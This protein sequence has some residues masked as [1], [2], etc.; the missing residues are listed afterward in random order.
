MEN[1]S[2]FRFEKEHNRRSKSSER[3]SLRTDVSSLLLFGSRNA[4]SY[5]KLEC[6]KDNDL[7]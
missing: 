3:V 1:E 7:F 6:K 2:F 5:S 4:R